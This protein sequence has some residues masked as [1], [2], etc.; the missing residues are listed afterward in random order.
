M[1]CTRRIEFDAGHRVIGHQNKCKYL[2]GHRYVLEI[3]FESKTLDDL[4]MVIDF[5]V[6]KEIMKTWIDENFDH[7]VILSK[8]DK[9]LGEKIEK[10][11]NQKI[12][13]INS[14][15]TA[16]NILKYLSDEII[17]ELFKD[18]KINFSRLKLYE[19]P[20]CSVELNA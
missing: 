17:P 6:V 11:T 18:Y 5:G 7:N 3:S 10:I 9:K 19:T 14:N 15:P 12:Y 13:Y 20:N 16:E 4:G 8:E 2:H 1:I